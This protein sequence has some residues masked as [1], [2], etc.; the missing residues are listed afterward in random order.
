[1][2]NTVGN[3]IRKI[4]KEKNKTLKEVAKGTGVSISFLSQLE[5]NKTSATLETLKKISLFLEVHPSIF[6]NE[7]DDQA[8]YPF[9]YTDLSNGI[10]QA[11]FKPMYVKIHPGESKGNEFSHIG[12][13]FIYVLKGNLT[14]TSNGISHYLKR[15]DSLMI[16]ASLN[17]YWFNETNETTEFLV[18]TTL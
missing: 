14:V 5:L 16:D 15:N 2:E 4:R 12:H 13:E 11:T 10:S 9:H 3:H 18:V 6:F 17:H 1:M 8:T 7:I